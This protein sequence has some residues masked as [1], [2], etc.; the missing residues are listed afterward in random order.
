MQPE[1]FVVLLPLFGAMLSMPVSRLAGARASEIVTTSLLGLTA[2][3]AW[4]LFF[5]V[6]LGGNAR[7]IELF[8]WISS[9]DF[10]ANWSVRLDTL[11]AIMLVVI[12]SCLLYTSPSPRDQRGSRM[13]SSA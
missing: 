2:L 12:N 1:A 4:V 6:A 9:G 11:S 10:I 7:T 13:P 8:T 5:D 3:Y